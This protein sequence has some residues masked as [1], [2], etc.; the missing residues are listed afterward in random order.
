MKKNI[1]KTKAFPAA[2]LAT[3]CIGILAACFLFGREEKPDFQPEEPVPGSIAQEWQETPS[4]TAPVETRA[5]PA[6]TGN[7][8]SP[9][10]STA[11]REQKPDD[12]L[13][14]YPMVTGE[15]DQLVTIDFT[16]ETEALQP[17]P[18]KAPAAGADATDPEQ[19]PSYTLEELE[20]EPTAPPAQPDT[21][22]A[23]ATG[24]NGA[25]YDPVFGWVVPSTVEQSTMDSA[26]DPDKMVGN[27]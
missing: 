10:G 9:A 14:A 7:S 11:A 3:A 2:A 4:P 15:T 13:E 18:P 21:P 19:P 8:T 17:E 20:P 26:G 16:P 23:G 24:E 1:F 22:A 6:T 25:V 12:I 5:T 27:M